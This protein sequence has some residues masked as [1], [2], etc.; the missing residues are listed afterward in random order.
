MRQWEME[1]KLTKPHYNIVI[2]TPGRLLHNTY[3]GSLIETT[4]WLT[5]RGLTYKFINCASS[6]VAHAREMTAIDE[7]H[8]NWDTNEIGSGKYTYDRVVWIDSDISWGPEAFEKLITSEHEII[9]GMYYTQIGDM[10]VSVS[11]FA[12]D[13]ISPINC[14]ELDFFMVDEPI[15]VFGVGFGFISMK[16]GVFE[17]MQRPWF[18]IE[19]I[20]HPE[21]KIVLD[22]GEDYSWCM[23]AR[24][25]G[26]KIMLDP[27]IKVD[28]HKESVWHLR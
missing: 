2:A 28:H 1:K 6:L 18:R 3:V 24:R 5:A 27:S 22:I 19:R 21:K 14:K 9:S 15:E 23:N 10:S 7:P 12:P 20:D 4:K 13:G 16:S 25:A 11:R 17:R 8:A 26:M